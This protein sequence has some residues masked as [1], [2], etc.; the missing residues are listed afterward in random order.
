MT[1]VVAPSSPP[2]F[3]GHGFES[4]DGPSRPSG[5]PGATEA[6]GVSSAT[7]EIAP[8]VLVPRRAGLRDKRK[9]T[10]LALSRE[11]CRLQRDGTSRACLS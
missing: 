10:P 8:G 11:A 2:D 1:D 5:I 9:R 7:V 4:P 6:A 3:V